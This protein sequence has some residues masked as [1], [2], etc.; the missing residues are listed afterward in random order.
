MRAWGFAAKWSGDDRG[1]G[2]D[3][4]YSLVLEVVDRVVVLQELG[5]HHPVFFALLA[6]EALELPRAD[7]QEEYFL[8]RIIL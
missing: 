4:T 5:T 7:E 6:A 1:D 3:E 8:L 2:L